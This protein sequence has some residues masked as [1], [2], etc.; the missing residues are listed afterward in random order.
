MALE[1]RTDVRAVAAAMRTRLH[2]AQ[3]FSMT[4]VYP[5]MWI[6]LLAQ[7]DLRARF[8]ERPPSSGA[9]YVQAQRRTQTEVVEAILRR[10]PL[11]SPGSAAERRIQLILLAGT[12]PTSQA[13]QPVFA[14]AA[15]MSAQ[16]QRTL[17]WILDTWDE[18][19]GPAALGPLKPDLE[20]LAADATLSAA[21]REGAQAAL[22]RL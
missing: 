19:P 22:A 14:N 6:D 10:L 9:A 1:R 3:A 13:L 18:R 4:P 15:Q 11:L 5:T 17:G 8:G 20:R 16:G 2:D 21:L 12:P 7:L